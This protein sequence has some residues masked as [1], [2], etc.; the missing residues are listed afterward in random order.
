MRF[1][2]ELLVD[3]ITKELPNLERQGIRLRVLGDV[4]GLPFAARKT[5][6][7]ACSRTAKYASM[8]LNL[9]LNYSGREEIIRACRLFLEA[10]NTAEAL[11]SETLSAY[12]YTAGQPDP[13]LVIRTSGEIRT[14]NFLLFQTAYSE[15]YFT[16]TLWP[17]FTPADLH[18]A[19]ADFTARSRRFGGL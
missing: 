8:D 17:D 11:T 19:I 16:N 7:Y 9:A 10:G 14:S 1:L 2:F 15:F 4:D 3:F 6:A 13:E 12:L 5:L 18:K